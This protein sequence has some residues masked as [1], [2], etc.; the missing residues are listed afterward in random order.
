[1]G[2]GVKEA[3]FVNGMLEFLRP[4]DR[5]G[6]IQV[7]EDNEGAIALAE[8][9]RSSCNSKHIDVRHHFLRNLT[10]EGVLEISHVS[11]E[12]KHADILTKALPRD[13]FE[14]HR[15]FALGSRSEK[16]R[17]ESCYVIFVFVSLIYIFDL[18]ET[19]APREG[20]RDSCCCVSTE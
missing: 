18:V 16:Y 7:R 17:S 6:K 20:V 14:V 19:T 2:D 10:E 9:P 1:M 4:G 8:N 3:L 5:I 13:L 12:G 15:N 11:S